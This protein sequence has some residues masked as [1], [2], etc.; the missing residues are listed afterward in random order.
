MDAA[1]VDYPALIRLALAEHKRAG[2]PF[3]AAWVDVTARYPAPASWCDGD[4]L[5]YVRKVMKAAY[6]DRHVALG[7]LTVDVL[8]EP[9]ATYVIGV[10]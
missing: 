10:G 7:G 2:V 1:A 9:E 6:A 5:P 4:L 3:G 8:D